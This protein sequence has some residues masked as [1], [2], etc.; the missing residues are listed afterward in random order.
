LEDIALKC[1]VRLGK[2]P[3][4]THESISAMKLEEQA[5]ARLAE[6]N[7]SCHLEQKLSDSHVLEGENLTLQSIDNSQRGVAEAQKEKTKGKRGDK[8]SRELKRISIQ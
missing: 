5:R 7:Y 2:S 8:L 4:E 1:E 3:R 6:E